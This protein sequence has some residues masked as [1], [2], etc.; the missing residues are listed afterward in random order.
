MSIVDE[1]SMLSPAEIEAVTALARQ[2]GSS[3]ESVGE[4]GLWKFAKRMIQ[5]RFRGVEGAE[6][7]GFSHGQFGFVVQPFD[8]AAGELLFGPKIVEDQLAMTS[9]G[10]G[11]FLHG[12][13][14]RAHRLLAPIVEKAGGPGWRA[15]IPELLEVLL[16]QVRPHR[17]EVV[18]Q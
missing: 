7:V 14:P 18:F 10:L 11:D 17:L 15:V 1:T 4:F 2:Y 16:E 3:V 8:H 13:D 6:S 12:L 5:R 9:Q